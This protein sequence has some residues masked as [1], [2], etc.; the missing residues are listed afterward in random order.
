MNIDDFIRAIREG[1]YGFS[2]AVIAVP[3]LTA[4]LRQRGIHLSTLD[5]HA[6]LEQLSSHFRYGKVKWRGKAPLVYAHRTLEGAST[7]RIREELWL[8]DKYVRDQARIRLKDEA[9]RH[10]LGL[11]GN[12]VER[13]WP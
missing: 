6:L 4:E 8:T 3:Y 1:G 5:T 13:G 11:Q 7:A 2:P 12:V 9:T 10:W